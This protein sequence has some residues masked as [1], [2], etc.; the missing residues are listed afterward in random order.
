[1]P[2]PYLDDLA[3]LPAC[4]G[5]AMGIDRLVMLLTDTTDIGEVVAFTPEQL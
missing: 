5:I 2:E 4:A 3:G 1:L